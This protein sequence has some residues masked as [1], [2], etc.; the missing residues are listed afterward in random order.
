MVRHP[1]AKDPHSLFVEQLEDV[2]NW[3]TLAKAQSFPFRSSDLRSKLLGPGMNLREI[4]IFG[5]GQE[6]VLHPHYLFEFAIGLAESFERTLRIDRGNR[7][8]GG[9]VQ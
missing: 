6:G 2:L 7:I 1:L 3:I 4:R 9:A 8:L 5:S